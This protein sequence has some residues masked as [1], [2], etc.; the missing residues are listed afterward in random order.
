MLY[1]L[2]IDDLVKSIKMKRAVELLAEG[3][4]A[5]SDISEMLGYG[6]RANFS[7]AFRKYYGKTPGSWRGE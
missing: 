7:R 4:H 2:P 6:D 3:G 5:I 1:Q